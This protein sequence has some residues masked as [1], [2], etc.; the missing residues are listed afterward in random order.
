MSIYHIKKNPNPNSIFQTP[1]TTPEEIS[2]VIGSFSASKDL[3]ALL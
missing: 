2:K 3:T 1:C